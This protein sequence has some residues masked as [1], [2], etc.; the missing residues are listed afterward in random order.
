MET[1]EGRFQKFITECY[2]L[3]NEVQKIEVKRAFYAGVLCT[4]QQL[5]YIAEEA[6]NPMGMVLA[7]EKIGT[8][9]VLELE[10][11]MTAY[12]RSMP[13]EGNA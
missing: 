9:A 7:V 8:D 10:D 5:D 4:V 1:L 11:L 13:T 6:P 2:E 3:L 12:V